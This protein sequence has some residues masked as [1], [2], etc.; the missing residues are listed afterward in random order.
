[1]KGIKLRKQTGFTLIELMFVVV[2]IGVLLV[3]GIPS[4]KILRNNN[5]LVTN[6]N[7]LVASLQ[8]ARSE[9][10]KRNSDVSVQPITFAGTPAAW[11]NGFEI[12]TDE[13]DFDGDGVCNALTIEDVNGSDTDDCTPDAVMKIIELGCGDEDAD[14]GLQINNLSSGGTEDTGKFTYRS[15]GRL[16]TLSQNRQFGICM[17]NHTGIERGRVVEVSNIGRPSTNRADIGNCPMQA[18]DFAAV[19]P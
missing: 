17:A 14:K 2:I 3:I 16:T 19:V 11:R 1:M 7:R 6:T 10:A 13:K 4:Y 8:F 12:V 9:A 5:C 15:S 18:T